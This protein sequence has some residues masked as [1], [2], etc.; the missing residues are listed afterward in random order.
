MTR[1]MWTVVLLFE[2]MVIASEQDGHR[3]APISVDMPF[4]F[5]VK[6]RSTTIV[7]KSDDKLV[8]TLGDITRGQVQITLE[9]QDGRQFIPKRTVMWRETIAFAIDEHAYKLQLKELDEHLFRQDYAIFQLWPVTAEAEAVLL[10]QRKIKALIK[11]L[12]HFG[13]GNFVKDHRKY[14]IDTGIRHLEGEWR[15]RKADI[16]TA[17]DFIRKAELRSPSTDKPYFMRGGDGGTV[18]LEKWLRERLLLIEK[19]QQHARVSDDMSKE[20]ALRGQSQGFLRF[21]LSPD[22]RQAL[23]SRCCID[24]AIRL[25]SLD[26]G[27][28]LV[29]LPGH[30]D[31]TQCLAFLR[32]GMKA[33]SGGGDGTL[34]LWD[35]TSGKQIAKA[36]GHSDYV[37]YVACSPVS[38][39]AVSGGD[40]GKILL[41]DLT[42]M[43]VV[44]EF[45]GH[46]SGIRY[47]CLAWSGD[48]KSV[49]SGSWDGSI[50]SWDIETGK[51][52][53]AMNAGYGRVMCVAMSHDGKQ[54]LSSYLNGPNQPVIH[55]DL[56][57]Q[58]EINRFGVPGNPWFADQSL[59]MVTVEFSREGRAALFATAYGTLICWNLEQWKPVWIKRVHE[60][61]MTIAKL[62]DEGGLCVSVGWD[63]YVEANANF[64]EAKVRFWQLPSQ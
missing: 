30:R 26:S 9:H 40:D 6:Q 20:I 43:Q 8:L 58:R 42:T 41:W 10:E 50:R 56:T 61:E 46:T 52:T 44:K 33:I 24:D 12:G 45:I 16:K 38:D 34:L 7:P 5:R 57:S 59:H 49:L 23:Y 19:W 47:Y 63:G 36:R 55:W 64:C 2:C 32:D 31:S 14:H 60:H 39:L 13:G 62:V 35:L 17:D 27:E 11:S 1:F 25:V 28:V 48:G 15:K 53:A 22:G 21:T 4:E 37:R 29:Q 18:E 54:A 3:D 51:E